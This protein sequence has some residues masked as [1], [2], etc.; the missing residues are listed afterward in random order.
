M[1]RYIEMFLIGI[2]I[3]ATAI[4]INL[5]AYL[6]GLNTWYDVLTGFFGDGFKIFF[7]INILS[8]IF[9]FIIYPFLLGTVAYFSLRFLNQLF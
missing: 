7:E 2:L 8:L 4:I 3:L 6:L 1:N 5:L 9:L